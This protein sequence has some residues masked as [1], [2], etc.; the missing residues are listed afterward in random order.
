VTRPCCARRD[1]LSVSGPGPYSAQEPSSA[2]SPPALDR[3][4]LIAIVFA[5]T[6]AIILT[7]RSCIPILLLS[8]TDTHFLSIIIHLKNPSLNIFTFAITAIYFCIIVPYSLSLS[9]STSF[10][11]RSMCARPSLDVLDPRIPLLCGEYQTLGFQSAA[12]GVYFRFN[13]WL[14]DRHSST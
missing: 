6:I 4:F 12:Q 7:C 14:H 1:W 5:I 9:R 13:A 8:P 3:L 10:Y 2:T 11:R